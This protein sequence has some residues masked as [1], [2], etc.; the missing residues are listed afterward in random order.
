MFL[1]SIN[2]YS[3]ILVCLILLLF[4]LRECSMQRRIAKLSVEN[5]VLITKE[6]FKTQSFDSIKSALNKTI[7]T[8]NAIIVTT[9]KAINQLSQEVFNLKKKDNK[10]LQTIAYLKSVVKTKIDTIYI[11]YTEID[12]VPVFNSCKDS[13]DFYINNTIIIPKT[14]E[15]DSPYFKINQNITKNGVKINNLEFI[16]TLHQ[17]I[18]ETKKTIE[19]QF[20][21]TNPYIRTTSSNSVVLNKPKKT[22]WQKLKQTFVLVGVGIGIGILFR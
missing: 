2:K 11:S 22:F 3:V 10:N 7:Y 4:S 6:K 5:E 20:F 15:I 21:H 13:L 16:D 9:E 1:K 17:R 18:V 8:Q 14:V 12:S 19:V